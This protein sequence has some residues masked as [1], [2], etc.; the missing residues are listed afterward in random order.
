MITAGAFLLLWF[1]GNALVSSPLFNGYG[2]DSEVFRYIGML[3]GD[4]GVPYVDAF[5]HKPP[6]IYFFHALGE[7]LNAGPWGIWY[8][9]QAFFLATL[10]VFLQGIRK[11]LSLGI[12]FLLG[13][14]TISVVQYYFIHPTSGMT[15]EVTVPLVLLSFGL[16][17]LYTHSKWMLFGQ[18]VIS[19]IIF[20]TQQ[21]EILAFVPL[22]CYYA[23]ASNGSKFKSGFANLMLEFTGA[24][25]GIL[26]AC[27]PLF[28]WGN[29]SEFVQQAFVFN[30]SDYLGETN[31]GNTFRGLFQYSLLRWR[32]F[33]PLILFGL[34]AII[35]VIFHERKRVKFNWLYFALLSSLLLQFISA[36]L[37]GKN[38]PHYYLGFVPYLLFLGFYC[39]HH[40]PESNKSLLK[41]LVCVIM[42]L[43][44][45][46]SAYKNIQFVKDRNPYAHDAVLVEALKSVE[47][48]AGQLYAFDAMYLGLNTDFNIRTPSKWVYSHFFKSPGFDVDGELF[49]GLLGDIEAHETEFLILP[50]KAEFEK[51]KQA[52][53]DVYVNTYYEFAY[54]F[55]NNK[56]KLYRRK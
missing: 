20:L 31:S 14:A 33:L 4:G 19:G 1:L 30:F 32:E 10:L 53:L 36:G 35:P 42:S 6:V 13:L 39:I 52:K 54:S 24:V 56:A 41:N 29:F 55:N 11:H 44:V 43:T 51:E 47:D 8:I 27:I 21:N 48:Q 46:Y 38:Y 2:Y 23:Y 17:L 37:S 49:D 25:A 40:L 45:L 28:I 50:A 34:L 18:G 7:S 9:M 26:L 15:R 22:L 12:T 5:D 16:F 3:I